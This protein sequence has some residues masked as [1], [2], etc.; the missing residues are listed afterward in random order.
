MEIHRGEIQV[1]NME[2]HRGEI[3][4]CAYTRVQS[5]GG[6]YFLCNKIFLINKEMPMLFSGRGGGQDS[7][8]LGG[9]FPVAPGRGKRPAA[10]PPPVYAALVRS[11]KKI[12]YF[13]SPVHFV[14]FC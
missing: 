3:Q 1:L 2:I 4:P 5:E 14:L 6:R 13:L 8:Y 9:R 10:T 7:L 12:E 11:N